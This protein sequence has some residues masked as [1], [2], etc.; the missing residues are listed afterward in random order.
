MRQILIA[1]LLMLSGCVAPLESA[2]EPPEELWEPEGPGMP[3]YPG[4]GAGWPDPCGPAGIKGGIEIPV[5]CYWGPPRH[6]DVERS[7]PAPWVQQM[8]QTE[9]SQH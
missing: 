5:E 8:P 6:D 9:Q 4:G 3:E 7:N 2:S 1:V